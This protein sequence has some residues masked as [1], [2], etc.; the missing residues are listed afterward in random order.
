MSINQL[1]GGNNSWS[2][3]KDCRFYDM[4]Y[5]FSNCERNPGDYEQACVGLIASSN[6]LFDKVSWAGNVVISDFIILY[7]FSSSSYADSCP[8]AITSDYYINC[9]VEIPE[10]K[11]HPL[12]QA[13]PVN[14]E[15]GV[16]KDSYIVYTGC[17]CRRTFNLHYASSFDNFYYCSKR[18]ERLAPQDAGSAATEA[19][20]LETY[21]KLTSG[22][23]SSVMGL[24]NYNFKEGILPWID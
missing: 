7:G 5:D 3:I 20:E 19:R 21:E 23:K 14:R 4:N 15:S 11:F 1:D 10:E 9:N 12:L 6:T 18:D 24:N 8:F 22:D 13:S 17:V 2:R 16:L